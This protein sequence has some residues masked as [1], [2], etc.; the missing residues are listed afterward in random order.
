MTESKI[1]VKKQKDGDNYHRRKIIAK[2]D[3]SKG[4]EI[5]CEDP[6]LSM[7]TPTEC[8][9]KW[10]GNFIIPFSINNSYITQAS[11][12]NFHVYILMEYVLIYKPELITNPMW[13]NDY[14][15]EISQEDENNFRKDKQLEKILLEKRYIDAGFT[16]E[17]HGK[18]LLRFFGVFK[19]NH[20][21][22]SSVWAGIICGFSFYKIA[23]YFNHSCQPVAKW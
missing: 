18:I 3:I 12:N 9:E 22:N 6:M 4:E 10:K 5:W 19:L 20:F 17:K 14:H 23:S 7:G 1:I 16:M 13:M 11:D 8:K 15:S 2:C 21:I